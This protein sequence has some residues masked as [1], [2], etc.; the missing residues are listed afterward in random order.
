MSH[1]TPTIA[2]RKRERTGSRYAQ[3]LR[4]AG[5]LPAVVYG[6]GEDPVHVSVNEKEVLSHLHHGAHVFE[7]Q[8]DGAA[9]ETCLVKDLQF[10]YLGDNVIHVDFTRVDLNERVTV[11]VHI[12]WVGTPAEAEKAGAILRHDLTELT[13]NCTVRSIPE[14]IRVDLSEM[15]GT[16]LTAGEITLP[17]GMTLEDDPATP[18][19]SITIA[20]EP[21]DGD[22]ADGDGQPEVIGDAWVASPPNEA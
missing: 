10:G 9:A 5:E 20:A 21:V 6:H 3:R 17:E 2:A 8:I 11:H 1:D 15:D 12:H 18:V 14:E 19:A 22:D 13:V 16:T 7:M 4:K